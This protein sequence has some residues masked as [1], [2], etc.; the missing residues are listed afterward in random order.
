MKREYLLV[1]SPTVEDDDDD[2]SDIESSDNSI[3]F[4]TAVSKKS[5]LNLNKEIRKTNK[6]LAA[7]AFNLDIEIP[8]IKLYINSPG[9]LLLDCFAGVDTIRNSKAPIHSI[10]EGSAASAGTILSVV[11]KKRSI[12][13]NSYMLIHQL[14]SG[15]WGKFEDMKDDMQNATN[16]MERIYEIYGQYTKIPKN[17]LKEILKHD[18]YFDAKTCL[19]YGLVD[20][21]IE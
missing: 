6:E 7:T 15:M 17:T 14:S 8:E 4:Y 1:K 19:K 21:I 3:Y 2:L 11:A 13:K 12:T 20:K 5:I 10:V 16:L 18:I 9:G